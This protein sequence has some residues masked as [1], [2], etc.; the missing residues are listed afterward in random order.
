MSTPLFVDPESSTQVDGA[1]SSRVP[2]P[3]PKD[4]YEAIKQ[5]YLDRMDTEFELFEDPIDTE[6]PELPLTMAPPI[7][8][9]KSTPPALVPI[10]RRT[11]RM[12]VRIPHAMSSGLSASMAKVAAM[13]EFVFRKRFRS[14][15]KSSPSVLP[16]D[17]PSQKRYQGMSELVEDSEEDDDEEDEEIKE[18]MDYDS[19]SKDAKDEGL[20][21]EDKDPATEDE[22]LTTRVEGPCMDDKSYGLD[23]ECHDMDD[24]SHSLDDKGH[25]V[26]NDG[27][28][29]EEEEEV[30]PK[31]QQQAAPVVGTAGSGSAPDSERPKRVSASRQPILTTWTDPKDGMVYIDI[32]TYPP[33]SPPV[34]TPPLPE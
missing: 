6:T 30:V 33:P 3:L 5:A 34:Q 26:E 32:P 16:I 19:L 18:S 10:L 24:E 1:Q 15:C 23:G 31:G 4:P 2:M 25:S 7:S 8:L 22:G 12:V 27:L 28:G 17:L 20:T 21:V 29:L 14:S 13:S 9:S 11:A